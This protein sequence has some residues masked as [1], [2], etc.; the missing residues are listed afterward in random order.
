M[1]KSHTGEAIPPIFD[2]CTTIA[3]EG[4][5]SEVLLR[6]SSSWEGTPYIAYPEGTPE[7]TLAI[8]RIPAN[9]IMDWHTHPCPMAV[10]VLSGEFRVEIRATGKQRLFTQGAVMAESVDIVHRGMT[11]NRGVELLMF[12]AAEPGLK[13]SRPASSGTPQDGSAQ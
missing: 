11:G 3:K 8:T 5:T 1:K 12:Y 2:C 9:S 10:Y 7:L 13:L 6:S 4:V